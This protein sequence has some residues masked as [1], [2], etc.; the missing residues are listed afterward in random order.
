[1]I[2]RK[3]SKHEASLLTATLLKGFFD[4]AF[5]LPVVRSPDPY[6]LIVTLSGYVFSNRIPAY[7]L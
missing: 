3:T 4:H 5:L 2:D 6:G 1:M 7:A